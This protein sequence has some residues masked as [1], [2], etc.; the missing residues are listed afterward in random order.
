MPTKSI[1][2]TLRRLGFRTA[3]AAAVLAVAGLAGAS[4]AFAAGSGYG[5]PGPSSSTSAGGFT[6]VAAS[7]T[8]TSSGSKIVAS[9]NGEKYA[10]SVPAGVFTTPTQ[11]TVYAPTNLGSI[12]G[13]AGIEV[14]FSD[15]ATGKSLS[16]AT[17]KTPI[18]VIV[19][20][21]SIA[22]GDV[23]EVFN[24][25]SFVD[26]TGTYSTATDSANIEVTSDPTFAL[27]PPPKTT[28]PASSQSSTVPG[29]TTVHTGKPF[30]GE[31]LAAGA[32]GI[33]GLAAIGTAVGVRRRR[34]A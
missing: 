24:G 9:S 20:S 19:S 6:T 17:L 21:S 22:K 34:S 31:E 18:D 30:F 26:Y 10:I 16:G 5:P 7:Q 12:G 4:P 28:V 23:V 2:S 15:P 8:V 32:A 13:L 33:L 29:A 1:L 25:S 3:A 11:V 14:V 27:V